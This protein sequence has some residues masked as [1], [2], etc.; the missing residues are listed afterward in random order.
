[1]AVLIQED[2]SAI[3]IRLNIVRLD[4]SAILNRITQSYEYESCLMGLTNVD[5][6]PNGQMNVWLSSSANHQWNPNQSA[7]ATKWEAE[8][9]RLMTAQV[10]EQKPEKRK[11]YFDQVQKIVREE[12]PFLYL[13]NR[14]ALV[15]VAPSV[16]NVQPGVLQPSA[17]WNID[18]LAPARG[19][20][21]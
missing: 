16:A 9:D 8:I 19:A 6:D 21:K 5:L 17:Y 4:F 14:N 20:G 15:A 13:V 7:P 1:M 3:G 10:S 11:A 18:V 2:L 12:A